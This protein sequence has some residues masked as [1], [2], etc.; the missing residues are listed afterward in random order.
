MRAKDMVLN[1][2]WRDDDTDS[3]T[4]NPQ[5]LYYDPFCHKALMELEESA[6]V[7]KKRQELID[8]YWCDIEE[9][10]NGAGMTPIPF[11][12]RTCVHLAER[13]S[14]VK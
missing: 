4:L 11:E 2:D 7:L 5:S 3:D 8:G 9:D 12:V 1:A 6:I 14:Y 13:Q 10:N